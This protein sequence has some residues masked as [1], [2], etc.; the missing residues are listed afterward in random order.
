MRRMSVKKYVTE[1]KEFT[2]EDIDEILTRYMKIK[3]RDTLDKFR[4]IFNDYYD[5]LKM[6]KEKLPD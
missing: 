2:D 6:A 3:D 1:K 5:T 4:G